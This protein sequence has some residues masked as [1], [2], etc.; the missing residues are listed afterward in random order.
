MKDPLAGLRGR[1]QIDRC[2]QTLFLD[3]RKRY[4]ESNPR[5][6]MFPTVADIPEAPDPEVSS[7]MRALAT[8]LKIEMYTDWLEASD[9]MLTAVEVSAFRFTRSHVLVARRL[10]YNGN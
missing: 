2:G 1:E 4:L 8:P 5:S 9:F 3:L 10:Q 7:M 6:A